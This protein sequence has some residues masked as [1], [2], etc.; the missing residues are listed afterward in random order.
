M[1]HYTLSPHVVLQS[2]EDK[3]VVLNIEQNAYYALNG[4]ARWFLENL[5]ERLDVHEVV[6]KALEHFVDT[7]PDR[8]SHDVEALV[9]ELLRLGILT[10]I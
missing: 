8:L 10:A 5:L 1:T 4:S 2:L 9:A 6:Q 3:L 7:S